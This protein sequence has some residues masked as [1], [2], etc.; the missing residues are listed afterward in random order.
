M[1]LAENTPLNQVMAAPSSLVGGGA[2]FTNDRGDPLVPSELSR[3]VAEAGQ[4]YGLTL[5][6]EWLNGAWGTSAFVIKQRWPQGDPKWQRVQCGELNESMAFDVIARF[7]REMRTGDMVGWIRD[8]FGFVRDPKAE[9]DRL[10]AEAQKLYA[11]A[12][13]TQL[14]HAVDQGTQRILD[15]SDHLRLVR[16]GAERP[17][18]MVPGADFPVEKAPD[19]DW[20]PKR[21]LEVATGVG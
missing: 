7:P 19:L 12:T 11:E 6:V 14:N 8:K 18:P 15:E 1:G 13:E 2:V 10:M 17:H 4:K 16:A 21:L 20:Q 3:V 9:A 5:T